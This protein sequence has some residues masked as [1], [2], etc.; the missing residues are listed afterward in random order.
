M[1]GPREDRSLREQ[2][3]AHVRGPV[4]LRESRDRHAEAV[5]RREDR[6]DE[7]VLGCEQVFDTAAPVEHDFV[8]EL[9]RFLGHRCLYH[10]EVRDSRPRR[11]EHLPVTCPLAEELLEHLFPLRRL[12]QRERFLNERIRRR[13][14]AT[15]GF[16]GERRG[17][18][19]A[20][21]RV[22]QPGR[23]LVGRELAGRVADF[24]SV[25]EVG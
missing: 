10:G 21:E 24:G 11:S 3:D 12:L 19:R 17:R 20:P 14:R 22:R 4:G 25:E 6:I 9:L 23:E 13:E 18:C 15:R 5:V 7:R 16:R 8:D 1:R 2:P